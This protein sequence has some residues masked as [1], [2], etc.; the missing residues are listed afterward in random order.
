MRRAGR[1]LATA[2][3]LTCALV[4]IGTPAP[5]QL[6]ELGRVRAVL[7]RRS[8]A[9]ARTRDEL[10]GALASLGP[11]A[12]PSLYGLV[13]GKALE[14]FVGEDWEPTRWLCAPED[15]PG[16]C[17]AAL[18]RAPTTQVLVELERALERDP[19]LEELL[20]LLRILG[21][22]ASVDALPVLLR[23]ARE[24]APMEL[25]SSSVRQPLREALRAILHRDARAF[26]RLEAELDQ[27]EPGLC[28]VV[29]EAI[30]SSGRAPGMALLESLFMREGMV[31]AQ[32]VEAMVELELAVPWELSGRTLNRCHT[33]L[34]GQDSAARLRA[35][36]LV[37][38]L[39]AL[40]FAPELIELVA[41][42]DPLVRRCALEALR[43]MARMPLQADAPALLAWL[44]REQTWR[45]ERCPELFETLREAP[46]GAANEALREFARHP[47]YRHQVARELSECLDQLPRPIATRACAELERLGSRWALPGLLETLADAP[48]QLRAA[49]W[50]ALQALTGEEHELSL[51]LWRELVGS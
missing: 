49:A 44:E 33:W 27:L 4:P 2:V 42:E 7:Q 38:R 5:G 50:R 45:N 18:E 15:V 26:A 39:H 17:V 8:A 16:L 19:N 3:A 1:L 31:P 24:I 30:G 41:E 40:E 25:E 6:D 35:I 37:G 23:A 51:E 34:E 21:A 48:P 43:S 47:L 22:H 32:V 29:V 46:P 11:T 14:A 20:V 13:S 10:V 9:D 36:G 28:A 12:V